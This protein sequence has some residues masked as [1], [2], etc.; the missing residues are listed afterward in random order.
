M[1]KSLSHTV[2][3]RKYHSVWVPTKRCKVI[4]GKL[5]RERGYDTS[6]AGLDEA[7]VRKYIQ[8]QDLND[9]AED[10]YKGYQF[11]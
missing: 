1:K 9:L 7:K 4:D 10:R 6:T 3:K 8:D 2:W 11:K 5:C